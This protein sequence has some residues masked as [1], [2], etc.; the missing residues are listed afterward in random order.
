[1]Y[2]LVRKPTQ[3]NLD[4]EV[5]PPSAQLAKAVARRYR[6]VAEVFEAA[7]EVAEARI[8]HVLG[9]ELELVAC[10]EKVGLVADEKRIR[11]QKTC[12]PLASRD[13]LF[14]R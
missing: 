7:D 4:P 8:R 13:A 14:L 1:M 2:L 3:Q 6:V 11:S 5:E 10:H 9:E 12:G